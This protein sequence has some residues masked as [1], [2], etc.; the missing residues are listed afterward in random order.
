MSN[1][2]KAPY[3]IP[4]FGTPIYTTGK[5]T[6]SDDMIDDPVWAFPEPG[7]WVTPVEDLVRDGRI[8]RGVLDDLH[9][10]AK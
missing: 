9:R 10:I 5:S 4:P 2:P 3:P 1:T 6:R 8:D 7:G